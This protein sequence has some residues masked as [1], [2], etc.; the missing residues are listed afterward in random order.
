MDIAS[1]QVKFF[2]MDFN[3]YF[4]NLSYYWNQYKNAQE[5]KINKKL[6]LKFKK[7]S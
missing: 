2:L 3:I 1:I 4:I 6:S 7:L 5:L